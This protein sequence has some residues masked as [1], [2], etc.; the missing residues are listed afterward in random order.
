MI[1][2]KYSYLGLKEGMRCY[3]YTV[4][5]EREPATITYINQYGN[6]VVKYDR[7]ILDDSGD[8][9]IVSS[10]SGQVVHPRQI[11]GPWGD[12]CPECGYENF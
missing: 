2:N 10:Y 12:V 8:T 4:D 7:T 5:L 3:V 11:E 1:K 9:E 6:V